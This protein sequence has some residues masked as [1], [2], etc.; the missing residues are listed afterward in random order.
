MAKGVLIYTDGACSGNPG[1]GGWGAVLMS[2]SHTKKISGAVADTT[3]NQMELTAVIKA[4]ESLKKIC[5][6][7]IY[8]DSKYVHDGITEWI[9]NW[10]KRGWKKVKNPL[11][12]QRLDDLVS[13]GGHAIN[14]HWVKGHN[15]NEF[16]E[17]ADK[18][19]TDAVAE[20][21]EKFL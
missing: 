15:D 18:L 7:D 21:K 12:W 19:A 5:S 4:L 3:N 2:G 16:N 17:M 20:F 10:K 6:V 8:T 1:V 9:A 14:W 13:N 11:L